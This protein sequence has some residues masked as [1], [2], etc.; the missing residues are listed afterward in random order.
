VILFGLPYGK[1]PCGEASFDPNGPVPQAVARTKN[2]AC[3]RA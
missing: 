2:A 3:G 1:D